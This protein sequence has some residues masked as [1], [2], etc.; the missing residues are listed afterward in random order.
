M[1]Y[2]DLARQ[3]LSDAEPTASTHPESPSDR[4]FGADDLQSG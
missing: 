2:A 3:V 4:R 1:I